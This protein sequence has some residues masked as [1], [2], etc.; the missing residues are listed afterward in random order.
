[1]LLWGQPVVEAPWHDAETIS[2]E[3]YGPDRFRTHAHSLALAHHVTRSPPRVLSLKRRLELNAHVLHGAHRRIEI[4]LASGHTLTPAAEWLVN[5]SHVVEELVSQ[6]RMALPDQ[7]YN[8]LPK[9]A[10]GPL[11]GYPRIFSIAWAYVAHTDSRADQVDLKNFVSAYQEITPL[12]IG[13]LWALPI[14]INLVLV[15][16][17]RRA[18]DRV[19]TSRNERQLADDL[20]KAH[21]LRQK[22]T[23][24]NN[25]LE[26][27]DTGGHLRRSYAVQLLRRVADIEGTRDQVRASVADAIAALGLT[28]EDIVNTEHRSVAAT[29]S[30]VRNIVRSM[31]TMADVQWATLVEDLSL[32]DAELRKCPT[33]PLMDFATRNSY[34]TEIERLARRSALSEVDIA[35]C[36]VKT[37]AAAPED[38]KQHEPGYYFVGRGRF[39]FRKRVGFRYNVSDVPAL[40]ARNGGL[41][42]YIASISLLTLLIAGV[43]V[44]AASALSAGTLS[45]ALIA[46]LALWPAME[47]ASALVNHAITHEIKPMLVPGLRLRNGIPDGARTF[48][49]VPTLFS[50][51]KTIDQLVYGLE[52]HHL[53]TQDENVFFA[54]L[55]DWPDASA[56]HISNDDG[57]LE[58]AR[59]SIARLNQ[60][61]RTSSAGHKRF[62][63]FHR[64]RLWNASQGKWMGWER[65]R[66]KLHEFNRLLRNGTGTSFLPEADGGIINVPENVKYV[67]TLDSDTRLPFA[68]VTRLV[69][70]MEHPLNIP[71]YSEAAGAVIDGHAILQPRITPSL[72]AENEATLFQRLF[73]TGGG[74]DPYAGAISDVYHDLFGQGSYTG[75]GIYHVDMFECAAGRKF[76]ENAILSHD[77]IEGIYSRAGLASDVEFIEE[78]P[79]RFDVARSRDHRW[80]RG[81]WQLLPWLFNA[82]GNA[83]ELGNLG[84]WKIADNLRRSLTPI[85]TVVG[86]FASLV[87]VPVFFPIW[88]AYIVVALTVPRMLGVLSTAFS[89]P[90]GI[91]RSSHLNFTISDLGMALAQGAMTFVLLADRA[92]AN[93]DAI[94]RTLYRLTISRTMLL[95]WTTAAQAKS[96]SSVHVASYVRTMAGGIAIGAMLIVLT[97]I[98]VPSLLMFSLP[99]GIVWVLSAFIAL[100]ATVQ[101]VGIAAEIL[102]QNGKAYLRSI[103]RETW[104]YF[105]VFVT[106]KD[107]YL[108]PDNFQESPEPKIAH[109]TSPSNIGLYLLSVVSARELGWITLDEAADRLEKTMRT[110]GCLDRVNG[111]FYNWYDTQTLQIL[112]PAYVSSVDSGNLAGH[113]LAVASACR[114]WF[115]QPDMFLRPESGLRDAIQAASSLFVLDDDRTRQYYIA[116]KDASRQNASTGELLTLANALNAYLQKGKSA[117]EVQK[118]VTQSIL[119]SIGNMDADRAPRQMDVAAL[120][121]RLQAIADTADY[122]FEQADFSI[123]LDK[124][125]NLFS[126]GLSVDNGKLDESCYDLLASEA[127]LTSLIAIAK[128]DVDPR[129]WFRLGRTVLPV[130]KAPAL[131]SWS[132]SMFEYLMP[133]LVAQT[134]NQSLIGQ[135]IRV[136]VKAQIDYGKRR[137]TPWGISESA[138]HARDLDF[139]YQYASHGIPELGLKRGL[140]DSHVIAPYATA[141][142]ALVF[143]RLAIQN[144]DQL[145][146]AGGRGH[147]GFY[148]A[149]D[150]TASRLPDGEAKAV[151]KS[152]MA[153]HQ[154]MTI[155]ALANVTAENIIKKYFHAHPRIRAAELLLHE[156]TPRLLPERPRRATLIGY[157][158]IEDIGEPSTHRIGVVGYDTPD[159]HVLSNSR[160][161]V[162]ITAAGTGYATWNG[163]SVTRW[164]ADA[165]LDSLGSF[166]YLRDCANGSV[167]S[168]GQQPTRSRGE[169]YECIFSEE[170]VRITRRDGTLQTTLDMVVSPDD[171]AIGRRLTLKNLGRNTRH[172]DVTSYEELVLGDRKSDWSHPAFSK[173]FVET[174]YD[175]SRQALFASRRKRSSDDKSISAATFVVSSQPE[176]ELEFETDRGA[177]I[178]RNR[179]L[180]APRAV[181]SGGSLHNSLGFVLD[182]A[183]VLRKRITLPPGASVTL[184]FWTLVG[185]DH[186]L[187]SSQVDKYNT[188]TAFERTASLAWTRSLMELRHLG[189]SAESALYFQQLA[190]I[191]SYRGFEKLKARKPT[192]G[193]YGF[194]DIWSAGVSGD[195]PICVVVIE[196][197]GDIALVRELLHAYEYWQS[198]HLEIDLVIINEHVA[199]YQQELQHQLESALQTINAHHSLQRKIAGG[200]V[201]LLRKD[202]IGENTHSAIV[203]AARVVL[204]ARRGALSEQIESAFG[205]STPPAASLGLVTSAIDTSPDNIEVPQLEFWN[206]FGG[207]AENGSEYVI[208]LEGHTTTPAPWVNVIA[209]GTIGFQVSAEGSGYTWAVNARERQLTPWSNDGATNRSGEIIYLRDEDSGELWSATSS[210]IRNYMSRYVVRHGHGYSR[211]E[212]A[213]N[214]IETGLEVFVAASDP[215]KLARLTLCNRSSKSRRISVTQYLELILGQARQPNAVGCSL[216]FDASI[217][218]IFAQ[219]SWHTFYPDRVAFALVQQPLHQWTT[220]RRAFLGSSGRLERPAA[221]ASGRKFEEVNDGARD[222]CSVL[223]TIVT[224][225][226]GASAAVTFVL[227]DAADAEAAEVLA[228]KYL[229]ADAQEVFE[230]SRDI[231]RDVTGGIK[232]ETPDRALDILVNGWLPY[233][234]LSARIWGRS[235]F[236]Q[237]GGAYGF[238]DQLQ[239]TLSFLLTRP[240]LC[241]QQ[242][243]RAA[244]RQFIE[245]DVLHWWLEPTGHGIRTRI[246]DSCLWLPYVTGQYV[247][248][249][250]DTAILDELVPFI[251]GPALAPHE[252]EV[253]LLPENSGERGSIYEHGARAIDR[254]M[255][256]GRNGLA[257]IG[258]G[259]WNDGMNRLGLAGEGE[260]VWLSWFIIKT[261]GYFLPMA[262]RRGEM[263]RSEKWAAFAER[264][265]N[266]IENS[267]W[268]GRWYR[269]ATFDDGSWIGSGENAECKI[270]AIAQS[271]SVISGASV[272]ARAETAMESVHSHLIDETLG[273]SRLFTPPF[274]ADARDPGYI[275]GYPV[276]VRENGGQYTHA[277]A[278][279]VIAFAEL[280]RGDRAVELLKIINPIHK[281]KTRA[282]A[283]VYRV[284]P[285][286]I[287]ADVYS[288]GQNAGRGGWT[289]YTGSAGWI[290]KGVIENLLGIQ[291]RGNHLVVSPR[292]PSSWP[293]YKATVKVGDTSI[294]IAVDNRSVAA[295]SLPI[296][297]LNG[298]D[299]RPCTD[300][301]FS[302]CIEG[303]E[304]HLQI[305][306]SGHRHDEVDDDIVADM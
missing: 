66:G 59:N 70:K 118:A 304:Q 138:F 306:M 183:F 187:L 182:P 82:Q 37:A 168:V 228:R 201:H 104:R 105:E 273:I 285:Y 202:L 165:T 48:V 298:L 173:L 5:N 72:P 294:H 7:Y 95:E 88:L 164:E 268:D 290:F 278:W 230:D 167:W 55:S 181:V 46:C 286:V 179:N 180:S 281:T 264:L 58:Y 103:S 108:P 126:V 52:T 17:L 114:Q 96:V 242:I 33:Y 195:L 151:I 194:P 234:T 116:L 241:K 137:G 6:I 208:I 84:R 123:L 259:D 158:A 23:I 38:T 233:Q 153:H 34:R 40:I 62:Y 170:R 81:D 277:A 20:I 148:D 261:I 197:D 79:N 253:Y 102:D 209:N 246:S 265:R 223:Q 111:H 43:P 295:D 147:Y 156:R 61:Y 128:G 191:V 74:I 9:L 150:Y 134:P 57:L 2:E 162:M 4:W 291:R 145:A 196:D 302:V 232:I 42:G 254:S 89:K 160:L 78:F 299:L 243:V 24:S 120:R 276:G 99:V 174:S 77:L 222:S 289:W 235:G 287:A 39:L 14:S 247:E 238:R 178:G 275:K 236:Y 54:L 32:V 190:G 269:R 258:A 175:P 141:L 220:D 113:L 97:A 284:E 22:P 83:G 292:I 216:R 172:F 244:H 98:A 212:N 3:I 93:A 240:S 26:I 252:H 193:P 198:K 144:F 204:S 199:S 262:A 231:W 248:A 159:C 71:E 256:T 109:R 210:P 64:K 288:E 177:F 213:Q 19:I 188:T 215:V 107:N 131:T 225:E 282:K 296:A 121:R 211:L 25:D 87:L 27:I 91:T 44:S 101:P 18:A 271:W 237:A 152:Y 249:T 53:A 161:N 15:E 149:I 229:T 100:W 76:P 122:F 56:E 200:R 226:P 110:L 227:G 140:S 192:G 129:H 300:G 157:A 125:R 35:R 163:L 221:L 146:A 75:K 135:T 8:Q 207:F 185:D 270:D 119:H 12:S 186:A 143:P 176:S 130:A 30:T 112:Q 280:G 85:M 11:A 41:A 154:G 1:V 67:V 10:D 60:T 31:R 13:E 297:K 92:F 69:G 218:G 171:D 68:A 80:V 28:T 272:R 257:L 205:P 155:V 36:A 266:A 263:L 184:D 94:I 219:N 255:S 239:D 90:S 139:N 63:I 301:S 16:N 267:A 217:N 73:S 117:S 303:P 127:R 51:E 136:A 283:Q 50:D 115:D 29:N 166:I 251:T 203:S 106:S 133:E 274:D 260:S 224:L 21:Q 279:N 45:V 65:K 47:L 142:A 206:G 293:G 214:G 49:V 86:F 124:E 169:S 245:G 305:N 250:N 132:G 189:I